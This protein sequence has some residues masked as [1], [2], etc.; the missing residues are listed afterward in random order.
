ML[1]SSHD[2]VL[3][4]TSFFTYMYRAYML[5]AEKSL[6]PNLSSKSHAVCDCDSIVTQLMAVNDSITRSAR[7]K[8]IRVSKNTK[9]K[10]NSSAY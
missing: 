6:R 8:P 10:D 5:P 2:F 4:F 9:R 1:F 7:D 3:V